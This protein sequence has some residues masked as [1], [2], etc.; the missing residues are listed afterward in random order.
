[1]NIFSG[2]PICLKIEKSSA[3]KSCWRDSSAPRAGAWE[4]SVPAEGAGGGSLQVWSYPGTAKIPSN[5]VFSGACEEIVAEGPVWHF[6]DVFTGC[7]HRNLG[8]R[9]L[10]QGYPIFPGDVM[11]WCPAPGRS[12]CLSCREKGSSGTSQQF[13]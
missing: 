9:C 10:F 1:M 2:N 6:R 11:D 7:S 5:G 12:L 3:E 8:G 13:C 4:F